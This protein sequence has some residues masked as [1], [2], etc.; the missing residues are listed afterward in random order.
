MTFDLYGNLVVGPAVERVTVTSQWLAS[1]DGHATLTIASG[2]GAG[3]MQTECWNHLFAPTYNTKP[4]AP[5][6]N[7]GTDPAVC[8]SIPRLQ[9]SAR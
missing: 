8:P 6:E 9:A 4:W 5:S 2:D 7:V 3:L 1:G